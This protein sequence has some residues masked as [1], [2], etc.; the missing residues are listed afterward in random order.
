LARGSVREAANFHVCARQYHVTK[1]DAALQSLRIAIDRARAFCYL[2]QTVILTN[3]R[4][5]RR[6][7]RPIDGP[8]PM[9]KGED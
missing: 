9:G 7:G 1:L 6:T 4:P 8:A 3:R 2:K 5:K